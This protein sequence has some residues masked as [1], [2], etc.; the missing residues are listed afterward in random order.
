MLPEYHF[1]T[2]ISKIFSEDLVIKVSN[3]NSKEQRIRLKHHDA[4][5]IIDEAP[6][7]NLPWFDR[8]LLPET[9]SWRF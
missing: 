9:S 5:C 7:M 6:V 8:V 1:V 3:S 4:S 2:V